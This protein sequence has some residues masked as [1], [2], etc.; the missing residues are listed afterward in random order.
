MRVKRESHGE[1]SQRLARVSHGHTPRPLPTCLFNDSLI[2]T[3]DFKS[4]KLKTT[5]NKTH[6]ARHKVE[7]FVFSG[8]SRKELGAICLRK[9][10]IP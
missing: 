8:F 6:S 10:S 3:T 2:T 4:D 5:K 7:K 1:Q 9:D